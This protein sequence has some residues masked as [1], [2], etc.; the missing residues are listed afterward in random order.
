MQDKRLASI[1]LLRTISIIIMIIANSSPY[2]LVSPH[3]IWLRLISSLAAPLFIF[4]S[5]YSFF[6]SFNQ[7]KNF[8]HKFSQALY[9]LISAVFVDV[10]IWQIMPFQTFDVLYLISF[11]LL[12]NILIFKLSLSLKIMLAVVFICASF[13][14]QF[15]LKYRFNIID[16]QLHNIKWNEINMYSIFEIK[17]CFIDG[18]FPLFPWLGISIL[19]QIVAQKTKLIFNHQKFVKWVSLTTLIIFGILLINYEINVQERQSYLELFYPP[20]VFFI[21]FELSFIALLM[22]IIHKF[23]FINK[24]K[25]KFFCLLGRKSLFIY[26]YHAFIIS[27]LFRKYF[28]PLSPLLFSVIIL[29]FI[30]SCFILAF[31]AESLEKNNYLKY[32][33]FKTILGLK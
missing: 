14:L 22:S 1:D 12:I 28:I 16:N 6:V 5:G 9:I 2:I 25:F 7:N 29:L 32:L 33:P 21:F 4:L 20:S 27:F 3:S 23:D 31:L 10:F 18:W 26:L 13:L 11:A 15:V 19:G 8:Y 30:F 24:P 17:R